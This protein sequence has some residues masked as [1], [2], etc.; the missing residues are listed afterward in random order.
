MK[1]ISGSENF[2]AR[3]HLYVPLANGS[4]LLT[5]T[6]VVLAYLSGGNDRTWTRDTL[7]F[8]VII[9][10]LVLPGEKPGYSRALHAD[11]WSVIVAP[12]AFSHSGSNAGCAVDE[13]YLKVDPS[14]NFFDSI[15]VQVKYAIFGKTTQL[16][17]LAYEVTVRGHAEYV[18]QPT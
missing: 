7:E 11:Q 6:G 2:A 10:P 14:G 1:T 15:P 13:F 12:N 17:R 5:L 16:L 4:E 18:P 3:H 9:P 8:N